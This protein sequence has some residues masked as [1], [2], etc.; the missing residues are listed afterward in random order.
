MDLIETGAYRNLTPTNL[1]RLIEDLLESGHLQN[2][3]QENLYSLLQFLSEAYHS[4]I[5]IVD[6]KTF[7]AVQDTY[8]RLYG[9]YK[10]VGAP[11]R[12]EK[13]QLPYYLGSLDKIKTEPEL[14]RWI[15]K[16]PGPYVLEDKVDG[17]TLLYISMIQNGVRTYRLYT[18][19]GGTEGKDVTHVIPFLNLPM[20]EYDLAVRGE[21][22]MFK[23]TFEQ[24]GSGF[25][26]PRNLVSG[27]FSQKESFNQEM[28]RQIH[29]LA[30][31]IV[32]YLG[33]EPETTPETQ[34]LQLR[35]VGFE[36][37][38]ASISEEIDVTQLENMYH[39]RQKDA[40]YEIDGIVIYQNTVIQYPI[41]EYPK[42]AIAFKVPGETMQ[43]EV[44][45]IEWQASKTRRLVPVVLYRPIS[46]SGAILS[47]ASGDNARYILTQSIG[48]GAVIEIIRSG[49]VI[50]R[51][52]QVISPASQPSIPDPT[53]YGEYYYDGVD[54]ILK[55]DTP[56]VKAAK[57]KYFVKQLDV[58]NLGP[59]RIN[60][61]IENGLYSINQLLTTTPEVFAKMPG[62][63][64]KLA[65]QIYF[66]LQQKIQNVPL[67]T[68][69][70]A[71]GI[72]PGFGKKRL[73]QIVESIPNVL[74]VSGDPQLTAFIQQLGGFQELAYKFTE[75][76]PKFIEWLEQHPMISIMIPEAPISS[77]LQGLTVVF[78]GFRDK[79]LEEE[80]RRRGGKVTTSVS[81]N[82]SLLVVSN[83]QD[84]TSKPQKARELGIPILQKEEFV[85]MY[86]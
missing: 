28:A 45:D 78:S 62:I 3:S 40:P 21:A 25:A 5:S 49:E 39:Q 54:F 67:P 74:N 7:D 55:E 42:Q 51:V 56:A 61:L 41:G 44:L 34:I 58:P 36:T 20:L 60:I 37:P 63:A 13:V 22:V 27:I 6:D 18:R 64:D 46:L 50:P 66:D 80:I 81:K 82:T 59:G 35:A 83:L 69:M 9:P 23:D 53:V 11:A 29:F 30:F 68:I 15:A 1:E 43:T 75:N 86:L 8:E 48:P 73:Q 2:V 72:F 32:A 70:A 33:Q 79:D 85:R 16:Y 24:I 4:G 12:G 52:V 65:T 26:N 10:Q 57:M 19:G 84:Q 47:K 38:W 77:T 31:R 76:L 17:I 14:T 71:S